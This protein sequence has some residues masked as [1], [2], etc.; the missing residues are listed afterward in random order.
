M[1]PTRFWLSSGIGQS[2]R[3]ELEAIDSAFMKAGIGYQNHV[4]VSS[5]PP[6]VEIYPKI[7]SEKGITHVLI[8]GELKLLPFSSILHVVRSMNKGNKG[9]KIACSIALTMIET[10]VDGYSQK[11]VLAFEAQNSSL[12]IAEGDAQRGVKKMIELRAGRVQ[13]DWGK[14]GYKL[15]S[16]SLQ[17]EKQFGC[18]VAFVVLDPFTYEQL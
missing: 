18:V 3:S 4:T 14:S 17:I 2:E 12:S 1:L 9:D 16:S 8:N 7:D 5:I 6:I 10:D 13:K 15:V 11:C